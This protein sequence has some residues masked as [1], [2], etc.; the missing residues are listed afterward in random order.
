MSRSQER[1]ANQPQDAERKLS[2]IRSQSKSKVVESETTMWES[3]YQPRQVLSFEE[4]CELANKNL[5]SLE[6]P[7]SYISLGRLARD[8]NLPFSHKVTPY[9]LTNPEITKIGICFLEQERYQE[10]P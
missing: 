6:D 10:K 8:P 3:S 7:N 1:V 4:M 5:R 9:E 2:Q